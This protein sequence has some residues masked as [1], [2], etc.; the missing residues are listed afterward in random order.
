MNS[1][2][3][4]LLGAACVAWVAISAVVVYSWIDLLLLRRRIR[5]DSTPEQWKEFQQIRWARE[6]LR[7]NQ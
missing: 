6:L 1:I 5:Q 3:Q 4:F 7:R 2:L